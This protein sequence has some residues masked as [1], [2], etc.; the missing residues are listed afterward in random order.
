VAVGV[1]DGAVVLA[2]S[3]GTT[4][5]TSWGQGNV[6]K[7]T[8]AAAT[9]MQGNINSVVKPSVLL[10][11]SGNV[12]GKTRPQYTTYA[13]SQFVSVR[14]NGAKGDG[15][16]DDT[17]ALQAIFNKVCLIRRFSTWTPLT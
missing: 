14:S 11:N 4:T 3:T 7:G 10:D 16:T 17:A 1:A 15:Q 6:F 5:I 13:P 12:F 8:N 2:G 9:F